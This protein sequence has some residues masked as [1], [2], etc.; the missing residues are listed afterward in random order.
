MTDQTDGAAHGVGLSERLVP[1]WL[2]RLAAVGWRVLVTLALAFVVI[3]LLVILGTVTASILIALIVGATF[4]PYVLQLRARGWNRT[5]AAAAVSLAALAV[6]TATGIL[7]A[8]AFLPYVGDVVA[9]IR[10][11]SQAVSEGLADLGAPPEVAAVITAVIDDFRSIIGDFVAGLVGPIAALVTSLI[12]GAFL[13]F[14]LLQDGDQA[15]GWLTRPI[16]GWRADAITASGRVALDR[17]G[18]YL[19]G[20]AL[21][22]ATDAISDFVF[23]WVLGVPLAGPLAVLVFIGGFVPYI[24]GFITTS[25]LVLVTLATNGPTDVVILLVLI[26]VMNIIQ[27]NLLA[28]LIYGRTLEVH[29][30]LVLIALPAGAALFGV[31][32]LFAALPVVAFALAVAPSVVLA[33]D[34]EPEDP[35]PEDEIVPVWLDRLGQ[36]SWRSLVVLGL[37]GVGIAIS[38]RIPM[39]VLPIVLA[40]VLASTLDPAADALRRRGWSR[41]QSALGVTAGTML[42]ITAIVI[43]TTATMIGPLTE[44]LDTAEIGAAQGVLGSIGLDDLVDAVKS[45]FLADVASLIA[46]IASLA[47][48][49]LLATLLTFYFLRDGAAV[50]ER[51]MQRLHPARRDRLDSAGGRAVD[52]LGGYMVGTGVVSLFGAATTALVMIILGLPLALPIAVLAF[53]LGYIPY[54]GSFLATGLAFLVTVAVGSTTDIAIMAIFTVVFNIAQGNFV[55][56]LVYGKAVN[57]HPAVILLAIPAGSA[58]AGVIGMFLVVPFLGVVAV[59]WRSILHAIDEDTR[60]AAA[61]ASGAS[62]GPVIDQATSS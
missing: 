39:V 31:V 46:G 57:L 56:P 48:I 58:L 8:A 38:V 21:L 35:E 6:L 20:T 53:F 36:W 11:G 44:M 51:G 7:L 12:L 24:G 55:A 52:V 29:P 4:A 50:W 19:R 42:G 54:I 1:G 61:A 41:G 15:W 9:A 2:Q 22:A 18:G 17:V 5:K 27:G 23:L 33:L 62:P 37:L 3:Q 28:P 34:D 26:T 16:S 30:A 10:A 13:T 45:G 47:V 43:V 32:G 40:V 49:L 14:F 25:V 59:T 60:A